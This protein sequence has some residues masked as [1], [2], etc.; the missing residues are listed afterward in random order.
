MSIWGLFQSE[1]QLWL[2]SSGG[3]SGFVRQWDGNRL[4]TRCE[5]RE[6]LSKRFLFAVW[7]VS[8]FQTET[9]SDSSQ[10]FKMLVFFFAFELFQHHTDVG[11]FLHLFTTS[12]KRSFTP[13]SSPREPVSRLLEPLHT[14]F[15]HSQLSPRRAA[16]RIIKLFAIPS[17]PFILETY[18]CCGKSPWEQTTYP[19]LI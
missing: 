8:D 13:E 1:G 11:G 2:K 3:D 7:V 12:W 5:R 4:H 15:R 6:T 10:M 19:S 9:R 14:S 18:G 16:S 17:F